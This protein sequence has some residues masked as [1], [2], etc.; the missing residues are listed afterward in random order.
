MQPR[1]DLTSSP[2]RA[3]SKQWLAELCCVHCAES[4]C[5]PKRGPWWEFNGIL[6][7]SSRVCWTRIFFPQWGVCIYPKS[8]SSGFQ[9]RLREAT[10]MIH[11]DYLQRK[12]GRFSPLILKMCSVNL[13]CPLKHYFL[14]RKASILLQEVCQHN[15]GKRGGFLP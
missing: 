8:M 13:V 7:N 6:C 1:Q 2:K 9:T 5:H 15:L 12:R 11:C 14:H 10:Q 3:D 4:F